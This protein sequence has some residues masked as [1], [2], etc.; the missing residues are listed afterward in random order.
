MK[1]SE[2]QWKSIDF[3]KEKSP[4]FE[5]FAR[6]SRAFEFFILIVFTRRA[7]ALATTESYRNFPS[8]RT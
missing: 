5:K 6:A 7:Q 4:F 3:H 2:N 1:I 8:S